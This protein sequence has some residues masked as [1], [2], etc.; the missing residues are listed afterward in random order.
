MR[1]FESEVVRGADSSTQFPVQTHEMAIQAD[2]ENNMHEEAR[3]V[4]PVTGR[5]QIGI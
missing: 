5:S 2:V 3:N 4:P 1:T